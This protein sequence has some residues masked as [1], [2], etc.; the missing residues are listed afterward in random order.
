MAHRPSYLYLIPHLLRTLLKK[1]ATVSFPYGPLQLPNAYRGHVVVD[2]DSCQGCGLCVRDC[3]AA[4]LEVQRL[5]GQGIHIL[6]Y[7]DRCVGCGQCELACRFEAIRLQPSF[8]IGASC[9]LAQQVVWIKPD[10]HG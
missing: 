5:G 4:A 9:R 3:P 2:V 6:H 1:P 8:K 10:S 7:S